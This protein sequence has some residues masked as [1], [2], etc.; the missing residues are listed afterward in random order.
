MLENDD[1][2]KNINIEN[3]SISDNANNNVEVKIPKKRGRKPRIK[4]KEELEE[5]KIPKKRG[6]KP[7]I[8]VE[9]EEN[10]TCGNTGSPCHWFDDYAYWQSDQSF[11]VSYQFG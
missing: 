4:T 6:R 8:K 11:T 5:I 3:E 1:D 7:K 9:N 2:K 10:W